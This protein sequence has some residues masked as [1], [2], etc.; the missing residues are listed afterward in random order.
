MS[1]SMD[2]ARSQG[3]VSLLL[4]VFLGSCVE[5][6]EPATAVADVAVRSVDLRDGSY[7]IVRHGE[8]SFSDSEV[9]WIIHANNPLHFSWTLQGSK[10]SIGGE[11][12]MP[13]SEG[14]CVYHLRF[15]QE[16]VDGTSLLDGVGLIGG[17]EASDA[18]LSAVPGFEG[19][20]AFRF[21]LGMGVLN[22]GADSEQLTTL[23]PE[24]QTST[25]LPFSSS[26]WV[27]GSMSED[28]GSGRLRIAS[29]SGQASLEQHM[30]GEPL[31]LGYCVELTGENG[32]LSASQSGDE[33]MIRVGAGS[34]AVREVPIGEYEG[35]AWALQLTL[36]ELE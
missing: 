28:E 12:T 4:L 13:L 19:H 7:G 16:E 11:S 6:G 30:L 8:L 26:G 33:L 22:V 24:T 3:S 5:Q 36:T 14:V 18:I 34:E 21:G 23:T 17:Q 10:G 27:P 15:S 2:R 35:S 29:A 32:S 31:I 20:R 25:A 1:Y 9:S